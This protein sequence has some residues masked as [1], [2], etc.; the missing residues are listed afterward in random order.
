MYSDSPPRTARVSSLWR[1]PVK[2]MQGQR[3]S[4]LDFDALG[5][6]GDR[7]YGVLNRESGTILSAKREGRLLEA[8]AEYRAGVLVVTL[9]SGGEFRQG[10]RLDE[11]LSSWLGYPVALVMAATFGV[12][13]FES[14]EDF[15]HDDSRVVSWEG[16]TGRFVDESALHILTSS[17]LEGLS[18]E[19]PE[20]TWDVR[21]FRPNIVVDDEQATLDTSPFHSVE[22]GE[23]VI[24]ITKLCSRC[25]M[26]TR[27]QPGGLERELD[28]LRHV[29]RHHEGNVGARATVVRLGVVR[30]GDEVRNREYSAP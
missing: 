20:L 27:P 24:E 5:M 26:T 4:E 17:E 13:T 9:P 1:Y 3:V 6:V 22:V 12:P 21:R 14:P 28:V 18:R 10:T 19:R 23:V 15:E 30:E 7:A 11:E 29:S 25:V 16:T 2:S 8:A